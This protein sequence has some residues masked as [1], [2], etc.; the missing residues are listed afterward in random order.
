M[1][2]EPSLIKLLYLLM[3]LISTVGILYLVYSNE[4]GL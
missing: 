1:N 3:A 4:G 2:K